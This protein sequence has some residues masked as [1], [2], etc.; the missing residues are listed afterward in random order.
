MVV[1]LLIAFL[2]MACLYVLRLERELDRALKERDL[3]FADARRWQS[4]LNPRLGKIEQAEP[5]RERTAGEMARPFRFMRT[6]GDYRRK[7]EAEHN[8]KEQKHNQ[9]VQEIANAGQ[10]PRPT[11]RT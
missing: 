9:L 3:A 1:S 7:Y 6:F 2:F 10:S 8:T 5:K 4:A 11:S